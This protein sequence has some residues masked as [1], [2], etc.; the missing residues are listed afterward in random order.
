MRSIRSCVK[1]DNRLGPRQQHIVLKRTVALVVLRA[2][3]V[4]GE[5][6]GRLR[7]IRCANRIAR[8]LASILLPEVDHW[9]SCPID[10]ARFGSTHRLHVP[11]ATCSAQQHASQSVVTASCIRAEREAVLTRYMRTS[12]PAT[13][14]NL[15]RLGFAAAWLHPR[16][17]YLPHVARIQPASSSRAAS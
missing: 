11:I 5:C 4:V 17:T 8:W 10:G 3:I 14:H 16:P 9:G 1:S 7:Q 2:R 15:V 12:T 6:S 13:T